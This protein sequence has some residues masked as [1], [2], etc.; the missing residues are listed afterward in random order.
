RVSGPCFCWCVSAG[1][2]GPTGLPKLSRQQ[3]NRIQAPAGLGLVRSDR[4]RADG[5]DLTIAVAPGAFGKCGIDR[6]LFGRRL[7]SQPGPARRAEARAL[8]PLT[9]PPRP[10][11]PPPP[12][13]SAP[14]EAA[15]SRRAT[16]SRASAEIA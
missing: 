4:K 13:P 10:P 9:P 2:P 8:P 11:P 1:G 5:D 12:A 14:V 15:A 16:S 6:S 7:Q 3:I